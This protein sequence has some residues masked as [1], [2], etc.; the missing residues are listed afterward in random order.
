MLVLAY[1]GLPFWHQN[2]INEYH[3]L[4]QDTFLHISFSSCMLILLEN[5]RLGDP[6]KLQWAQKWDPTS[7][8]WR[9]IV[10]NPMSC[11]RPGAFVPRPAF[12]EAI[13]ITLSF[14]P[15]FSFKAHSFDGYWLISF[16]CFSLYYCLYNILS[17]FYNTTANVNPLSLSNFEKIAPHFNKWVFF[18]FHKA[19][20]WIHTRDIVL[21]FH[22]CADFRVPLDPTP[23]PDRSHCWLSWCHFGSM[24]RS[25]KVRSP[26][27]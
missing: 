25:P 16:F 9:Q 13:I 22:I 21:L 23:G 1:Q 18:S 20:M 3:V 17:F 7:T 24:F 10:N 12:P 11:C 15:R 26:K 6:F 2:S 19:L 5:G 14:G 8:K 4:F 27:S